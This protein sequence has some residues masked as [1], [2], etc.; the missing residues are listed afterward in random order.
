[1]KPKPKINGY[2]AMRLVTEEA[3]SI[4]INIRLDTDGRLGMVPVFKTKK[5]ASSL[6][7]Q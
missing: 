6:V 7:F 4:G 3:T 1:M 2:V 5:S